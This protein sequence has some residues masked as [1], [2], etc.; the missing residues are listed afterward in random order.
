[1]K[2]IQ[3]CKKENHLNGYIYNIPLKFPAKELFEIPTSI[4]IKSVKA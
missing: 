2:K 4:L 3:I 1:M